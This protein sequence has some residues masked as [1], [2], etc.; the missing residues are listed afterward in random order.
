M[1][2]LKSH[3]HIYVYLL[4]PPTFI[5]EILFSE[6]QSLLG[7]DVKDQ[8]T[9]NIFKLLANM[10]RFDLDGTNSLCTLLQSTVELM[11]L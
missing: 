7:S 1:K 10:L 2:T 5:L 11:I 9:P 8:S 6:M 3:K 4:A